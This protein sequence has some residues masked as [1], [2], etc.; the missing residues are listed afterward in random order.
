M[1]VY[2]KLPMEK[3]LEMESVSASVL[4][5][6]IDECPAQAWF[7]SYLN[8]NRERTSSAA[9]NIGTIAHSILLEGSAGNVEVIDPEHYPADKTGNIPDG[10]TNKA[11]RTARDNAVLAGKI[12]MLKDQFAVTHAMVQSAQRFIESL[13][14]SEPAIWRMFQK[15]E[16]ESELTIT[17]KDSLGTP[18]RIR[19]DRINKERNMIV[20]A[21]FT[22]TSPN[23]E[24]WGRTQLISQGG[25]MSAA[26]YRM[27]CQAEF[28]IDPEYVFLV[29][30]AEAPYLCS[31]VG[32]DPH[33]F[34][35]G[36][37]KIMAALD[38]WQHCK[39][40]SYWPAYPPRVCYPEIPA[41]VDAQWEAQ[42]QNGIDFY[43]VLYADMKKVNP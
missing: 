43:D 37:Q 39:N 27:G 30:G 1:T 28:R 21:K 32:V 8:P 29:V 31:L 14:T 3:Y 24:R 12:P 20:D 10:W 17:W 38:M 41:Y 33:G 26:F 6:M 7:D 22:A 15:G 16:G 35:L 9:M 4:K 42:Q 18:C 2:A 13:K 25:Y 11:I 40:I 23:P 36:G 34:D 19:P 5:S